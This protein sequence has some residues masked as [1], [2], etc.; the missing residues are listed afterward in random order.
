M[1]RYIFSASVAIGMTLCA[2]A[3]AQSAPNANPACGHTAALASQNPGSPTT[4]ADT[5]SDSGVAGSGASSASMGTGPTDKTGMM[6]PC[7]P[8]TAGNTATGALPNS[9]AASK[10]Q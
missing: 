1:S 6:S 4:M 3:F 8:G 5:S 7:V 9:S 10:T 2:S